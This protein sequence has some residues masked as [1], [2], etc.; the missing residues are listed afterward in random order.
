[1]IL[2][3]LRRGT[4]TAAV[5]GCWRLA[6]L[7]LKTARIAQDRTLWSS[8]AAAE[9]EAYQRPQKLRLGSI[10]L[11]EDGVAPLD[12][13]CPSAREGLLRPMASESACAY[14][15]V[16]DATDGSLKPE[17]DG[18]VGAAFAALGNSAVWLCLV[19]RC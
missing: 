11:T 16:V 19:R 13:S 9:S 3:V 12:L 1:M 2:R 15:G 6:N 5:K 7:N 18:A 4:R 14:E 10:R 8:N 17:H